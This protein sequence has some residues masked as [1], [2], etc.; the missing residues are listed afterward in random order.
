MPETK[1]SRYE[2]A[3]SL[4]SK[5]IGCFLANQ[6]IRNAVLYSSHMNTFRRH[7]AIILLKRTTWLRVR[8]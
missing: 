4:L 6:P 3:E 1:Q 5:M 2:A 7:I 8:L